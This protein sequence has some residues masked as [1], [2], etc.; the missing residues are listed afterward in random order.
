MRQ[1]DI[2]AH[3]CAIILA[4]FIVKSQFRPQCKRADRRSDALSINVSL[5]CASAANSIAGGTKAM[6]Y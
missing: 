4:E 3:A 6:K 1:Q 2:P 5:H